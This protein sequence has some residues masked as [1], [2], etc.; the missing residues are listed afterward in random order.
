MSIVIFGIHKMTLPVKRA[1]RNNRGFQAAADV[2]VNSPRQNNSQTTTQN[3]NVNIVSPLTKDREFAVSTDTHPHDPL[4][5][6]VKPDITEC[7]KLPV[8]LVNDRVIR[9]PQTDTVDIKERSIESA[10]LNLEE[11]EGIVKDKNSLIQALALIIDL[12]ENNPLIVNKLI[13]A[14]EEELIKLL[15][16][17]TGAD[18]VEIVKKD[19]VDGGCLCKIPKYD[20][21]DK[22]MIHKGDEMY[23]LKYSYPSVI[24]LLDNRRVSIKIVQND[25]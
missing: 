13:V 5:E 17:L 22:I 21:V 20:L 14:H 4:W 1:L 24:R 10:M 9:P 6:D 15:M 18:S 11:M 25:A 2:S 16:L 12:Y 7:E 23:N 8:D 19:I 3:V